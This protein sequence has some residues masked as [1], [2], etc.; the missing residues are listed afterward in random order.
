MNFSPDL[1]NPRKPIINLL[2]SDDLGSYK[3][4]DLSDANSF[5]Q[6]KELGAKVNVRFPFSV[7]EDQKG[8]LRTG[9]RMRLKEK[10]RDNTFC[11]YSCKQYGKLTFCTHCIS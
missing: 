3:L 1:S 7:I 5:T 10:E 8:R 9:F 2:A 6:E 4:S 11:L